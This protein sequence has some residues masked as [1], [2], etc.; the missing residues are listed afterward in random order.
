MNHREETQAL[1]NERR[2]RQDAQILFAFLSD[3]E[4]GPEG[5]DIVLAMGSQDLKVA[6]TA[7]GAFFDQGAQWLI[8]SGGF[9]KD[10]SALFQKPEGVLYAERCREL[11]VPEDRILVE[12]RAADSGENFQFSRTVLAERGIFP[13]TGV[14]ACKPYMARRAWAT[15]AKQWPEIRWSVARPELSFQEYISQEKDRTAVLELVV[16]DLQRLRVYAGRFQ[17]PL[18]VPDSIWSAG[19]RLAAAGDDRY[20]IGG[21]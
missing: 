19:K 20:V 14:I 3:V 17:E 10:T 4:G 9:G 5:A 13:R 21:I 16:G 1:K 6:D 11:G 2:I 12:Y 18:E 8:C 7:A 15:G